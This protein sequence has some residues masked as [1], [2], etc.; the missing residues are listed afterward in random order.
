MKKGGE[1]EKKKG[2]EKKQ[3]VK[4]TAVSNEKRR[5]VKTSERNGENERGE[6]K[7]GERKRGKKK[8]KRAIEMGKRMSCCMET[9]KRKMVKTSER[10]GENEKGETKRGERKRR[11]NIEKSN[12][13]RKKD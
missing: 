4:E 9:K 3:K 6:T 13:K 12:R 2:Y 10:N 5:M 11:K 8:L 1:S 7:R